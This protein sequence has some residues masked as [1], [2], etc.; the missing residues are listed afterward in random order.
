MKKA[1]KMKNVI[2]DRYWGSSK[3]SSGVIRVIDNE[4]RPL[5]AAITLERGWQKNLPF[6]SCIPIGNYIIKIEW[7]EKFQKDLWEIKGVDNRS[8]C[9]FHV[10]NFWTDL[11]GCVSLGLKSKKINADEYFDITNSRNTMKAF[12]DVL[13]GSKE[14]Y[15]TINDAA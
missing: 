5:F 11:E 3:Q 14:H 9:K 7:S 2:I 1:S 6:I 15:L 8:E 12:H 13:K 10:A 4:C